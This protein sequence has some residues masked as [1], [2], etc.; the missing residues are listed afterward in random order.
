MGNNDISKLLTDMLRSE[1]AP[2]LTDS[3]VDAFLASDAECHE[4]MVDRVRARFVEKVLAESCGHDIT[5][6]V[7]KVPFGRWME[8]TREA[9]RLSRLDLSIAL[10]K[11]EH[12]VEAIE[13]G[14]TMPWQLKCTE[15]ARVVALFRLHIHA[16]SDLM[17]RSFA[18]S[19]AR[20]SGEV[21]ARSH[22][23]KMSSDR[24]SSTRRALDMYLAKNASQREPSSEVNDCL[25][26]LRLELR[27]M[28]CDQLVD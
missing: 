25:N 21:M 14:N 28:G 20:L 17:E 5:R 26:D 15:L 11:H 2:P 18:L 12:F 6:I 3:L 19:S 9:A 10:G 13:I 16:L 1:E 22:R 4:G 27:R 23:G 8:Q 7:E 24:G